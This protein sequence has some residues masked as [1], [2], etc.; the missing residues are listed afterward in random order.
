LGAIQS[1]RSLRDRIPDGWLDGA[2]IKI[3]KSF[4][5][6]DW[7]KSKTEGKS[8]AGFSVSRAAPPRIAAP[9]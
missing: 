7:L 6:T 4:I 2:E 5:P 8:A 9:Q 1:N 3:S